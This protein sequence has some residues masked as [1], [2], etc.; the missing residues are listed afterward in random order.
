MKK[1]NV[2]FSS[3]SVLLGLT[4]LLGFAAQEAA[5]GGKTETAKDST[6]RTIRYAFTNTI[7]PYSYLDSSGKPTGYDV[8]VIKLVAG[9]LPQYSIEYVGTTSEDAW[10]GV[11]TGKY[12]LCTTNSIKTAAREEKYLF[13]DQNQGGT[14]MG[15]IL[16]VKYA[17]IK[18]LEDAG[19][20]KLRLVPLRPAESTYSIINDYNRTHPDKQ[21][22]LDA[23]DQF[24]N[25]D[26]LKWVGEGRYDFWVFAESI[27]KS[28]VE[29]EGAQLADLRGKLVFNPVT[30]WAT[31]ALINKNETEFRDAYQAVLV[32]L[33]EEG[34]LSRLSGQYIGIDVFQYFE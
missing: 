5:A 6:V 18:T 12:Q 13:A 2:N 32:Q 26:G 24:E 33:K 1:R 22:K 25:A 14:L 23:I 8:E 4:L 15:M 27:F 7:P 16:P 3:L 29:N 31:Y 28:L 30:A 10:L 34:V 11:E 17:D 9:R 21:I 19:T 20:A